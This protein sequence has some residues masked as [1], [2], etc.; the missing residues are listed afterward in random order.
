[1]LVHDLEELQNGIDP[2]ALNCSGS[3][4]VY[5]KNATNNGTE[6]E[7]FRG[8]ELGTRISFDI[9]DHV[10]NLCNECERP[11]G[12]CGV[13]LKCICHPRE[14]SKCT[15]STSLCLEKNL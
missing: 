11:N 15:I 3:R 7:D 5:K 1:M 4:W 2:K 9:P 10:P 13:G 14:C 6:S 12:N 8:Y